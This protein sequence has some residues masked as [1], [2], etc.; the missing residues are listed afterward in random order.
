M[1]ASLTSVLLSTL[2][3]LVYPGHAAAQYSHSARSLPFALDLSP[4]PAALE[5][6]PLMMVPSGETVTLDATPPS[7]ESANFTYQW[8]FN[9]RP[10][11]ASVG[12][13]SARLPIQGHA[14]NQGVWRVVVSNARGS[15]EST[16]D[17]QVP[18]APA[19]RFEMAIQAVADGGSSVELAFP[20]AY[21]RGYS[22]QRSTD[23]LTWTTLESDV[24]G[25]GG[26]LVRRYPSGSEP[27]AFYRAV[28]NP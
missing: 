10:I 15:T 19:P 16:F 12:G 23:L 25:Q 18:G 11:P 9:G 8:Y 14:V 6:A 5:L 3:L 22:I 7:G 4:P 27:R 2:P 26:M 28:Q 20:A 13:A 21:G 1:K 24:P 17:F